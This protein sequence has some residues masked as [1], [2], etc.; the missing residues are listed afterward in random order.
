MTLKRRRNMEGPERKR[1]QLP[2]SLSWSLF[3]V[4]HRFN[5][6]QPCC[7]FMIKADRLR[8]L[9]GS[10]RRFTTVTSVTSKIKTSS[11]MLIVD[12]RSSSDQLLI[13][14]FIISRGERERDVLFRFRVKIRGSWTVMM[15][16]TR[17]LM[18]S[19]IDTGESKD[20]DK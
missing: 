14:S 5:C 19:E 11:S 9:G 16:I 4:C 3:L 17:E 10:Y 18:A 6:K 2:S 13:Y 8:A 15:M 7:C 1:D 20:V 12:I